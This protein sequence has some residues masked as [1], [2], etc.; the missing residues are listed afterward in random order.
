MKIRAGQNIDLG[1]IAKGWIGT[2]LTQD[3]K[4]AG[5]VRAIV[6]L[7]GNVALLNSA[8]SG[9]AWRVGVQDPKADRGETLAVI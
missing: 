1:A 3:L 7:G 6:D 4:K 9:R 2:A 5:A 8:P